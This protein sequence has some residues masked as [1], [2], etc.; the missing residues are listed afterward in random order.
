MTADV[1]VGIDAWGLSGS[2]ARTGMGQYAMALLRWLPIV[3][4]VEIVA[5][6]APGED[7]PRW[8]PGTVAWRTPGARRL[9][10]MAAI[11]S[12]TV[13]FPAAAAADGCQVFHSPAVHVRPSF[14]PLARVNCPR[15]ATV[16]DVIP[17]SYYGQALPPRV[18]A[19]YRWNLGRVA[20]AD[21][22]LTVS[23]HARHEI[24]KLRRV[25]HERGSRSCPPPSIST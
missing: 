24:A 20:T 16:H 17:L 2:A 1:R 23:Q 8:L 11:H 5:Y 21:R 9:G 19:Y 6:G 22:I 12:R 7:R 14:P 13:V 15:I 25:S 10:R 18:R 4:G 3:G